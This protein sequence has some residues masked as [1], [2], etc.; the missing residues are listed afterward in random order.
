VPTQPT[1]NRHP[2]WLQLLPQQPARVLARCVACPPAGFDGQLVR[3]SLHIEELLLSDADEAS[4]A[5]AAPGVAAQQRPR[6]AAYTTTYKL[7]G[8][9]ACAS[10][11]ACEG[12]LGRWQ[13][14]GTQ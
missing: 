12:R 4:A 14:L 10:T 8:V 9:R 2:E 1:P 3:L 6:I 13:L 11:L 7:P 5:A